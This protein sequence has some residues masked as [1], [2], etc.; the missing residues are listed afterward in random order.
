MSGINEAQRQTEYAEARLAK[1]EWL[2]LQTTTK[3][4]E[5][6]KKDEEMLIERIINQNNLNATAEV[7]KAVS[8]LKR[9]RDLRKAI[10]DLS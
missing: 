2:K 8:E 4:V 9:V 6:L 1:M 5:S 7:I 3:L 10:T